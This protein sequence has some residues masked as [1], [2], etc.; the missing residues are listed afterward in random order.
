M[1]DRR[2]LLLVECTAAL[3]DIRKTL[4]DVS[5]FLSTCPIPQCRVQ[6]LDLVLAEVMTNIARHGYPE[7]PGII[8]LRL[9]QT[10]YA[11][12]CRIADQGDSFDPSFLGC[13]RPDP[14]DL[15]EG[16]YGWF[17]I[18]SL[19]RQIRYERMEGENIL[20]FSVPVDAGGCA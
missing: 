20:L 1:A 3:D 10:P 6:E 5:S 4:Q 18:R 19:A 12:E 15:P 17:I 13:A 16:G 8:S 2:E 9:D 7:K 11:L 14:C